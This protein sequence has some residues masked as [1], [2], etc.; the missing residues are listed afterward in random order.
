MAKK[1]NEAGG[2]L[3]PTFTS[4]GKEYYLMVSGDTFWQGQTLAN[5]KDALAN[6]EYLDQLVAS[7]SALVRLVDFEPETEA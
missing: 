2:T 3:P 6:Q 4:N 1:K 5:V 7:E